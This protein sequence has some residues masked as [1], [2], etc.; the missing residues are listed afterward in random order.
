M[1]T[2]SRCAALLARTYGDRVTAFRPLPDGGEEELCRDVRCALSRTS[3]TAAPEPPDGDYVLPEAL[4]RL[5]LYTLPE[6]LFRLGDWVE[7]TDGAGRVFHGRTSDS[8]RY[9]SHAVTVVAVTAVEEVGQD[10]RETEGTT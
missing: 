1:T 7:V 6:R 3:H 4:Y 9:P 10:S 8:F 5:T 2:D